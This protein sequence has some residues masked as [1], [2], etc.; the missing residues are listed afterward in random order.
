MIMDFSRLWPY[1]KLGRAVATGREVFGR[2]RL[3]VVVPDRAV[4]ADSGRGNLF[5]MLPSLVLYGCGFLVP[6]GQAMSP[7][8]ASAVSL[9]CSS[10]M[11]HQGHNAAQHPCCCRV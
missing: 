6:L 3:D 8:G 5:G 7:S 11:A 2:L 4:Q 1:Q 9:H 10:M